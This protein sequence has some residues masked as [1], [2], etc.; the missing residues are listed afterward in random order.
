M[1]YPKDLSATIH[2]LDIETPTDVVVLNIV[3]EMDSTFALYAAAKD[4]KEKI[5]LASDHRVLEAR[6]L[7]TH[8]CQ[9]RLYFHSATLE[10]SAKMVQLVELLESHRSALCREIRR[11]IG[12][13][14]SEPKLTKGDSDSENVLR[15][16]EELRICNLIHEVIITDAVAVSEHVTMS[17]FVRWNKI[18]SLVKQTTVCLEPLTVPVDVSMEVYRNNE[19]LP[20]NNLMLIK[21]LRYIYK[22]KPREFFEDWVRDSHF[23]RNHFDAVAAAKFLKKRWKEAV[24]QALQETVDFCTS[25]ST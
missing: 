16:R 24:E 17:W 13:C 1:K 2:D 14:D 7:E 9:G 15:I 18:L 23:E 19:L 3:Q 10:D 5:I 22:P 4:P 8:L 11:C 12:F 25:T 6:I 20:V 21:G